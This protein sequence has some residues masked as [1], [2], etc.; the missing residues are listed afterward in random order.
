MFFVRLRYVVYTIN[1]LSVL[2]V[3]IWL[4]LELFLRIPELGDQFVMCREL[5]P[6]KHVFTL[7]KG[8]GRGRWKFGECAGWTNSYN[9]RSSSK[10]WMIICTCL[11]IGGQSLHKFHTNTHAT[12]VKHF[13]FSPVFFYK[14]L[15][16]YWTHAHQCC[17]ISVTH[18]WKKKS[19]I[20]S[21]TPP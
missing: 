2:H 19:N 3:G 6:P 13:W 9:L 1:F 8:R 5:F 12:T 11:T 20:T 15:I 16:V 14:L 7:R 10:N 4:N 17:V 21:W 18:S